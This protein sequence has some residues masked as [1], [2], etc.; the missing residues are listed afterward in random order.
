[1]TKPLESRVALLAVSKLVSLGF[2]V[3]PLRSPAQVVRH[4]PHKGPQDIP[5]EK[6]GKAPV[7]EGWA[8]QDALGIEDLVRLWGDG[9]P[10][11]NI[12]IRTGTVPGAGISVIVVDLDSVE[13]LMW[14][15]ENLPETQIAVHTARGQHW[16]YRAPPGRIGN[17][18]SVKIDGRPEPLQIDVRGDG[19]QAVAPSSVH[20]TGHRY[21][22]VLPWTPERV[23]SM[24]T[25]DP[26][27]FGR[28]SEWEGG[29]D[30]V[31][32]DGGERRPPVYVDHAFKRKRALAYL[33]HAPGTI[34]GQGTASNECLYYARALVFGLCLPP[35]EAARIMH[36]HDWN[37]RCVNSSGEPYPWTLEEL[38]H[39]CQDAYRLHFN[40]DFGYLLLEQKKN[41]EKQATEQDKDAALSRGARDMEAFAAS[42][43]QE[44][45]EA[46]W[47]DFAVDEQDV[48]DP[49]KRGWPLTDTGN[50]E[51]LVARFGEAVRY[52]E[53]REVWSA[54]D[55]SS[56]RW[57]V[58]AVALRR[59]SKVVARKIAEEI[60]AAEERL[61]STVSAAMDAAGSSVEDNDEAQEKIKAAEDAVESL[62]TWQK[63]SESAS[64]RVAMIEMAQ[65]EHTIAVGSDC[66]DRYPLLLNVKNGTL[67]LSQGDPRLLP[68]DRDYYLTKACLVAWDPAAE[69][70]TWRKCL[71]DW[72]GGDQD[73]ID[74]LQRAAGYAA[75]GSVEEEALFLF[76]G[77]GQNGKSTFLNALHSV[78]GPYATTA[79]AG[80]LMETR[81]D[82]ATPS[83][84]AGLAALVGVRLVVASESDES[85]RMSE[86]QVKAITCRDRIS[87]KR[88]YEAPF[89][90]APSHHVFLTTNSKPAISGTDDGIWRRL[91]PLEWRHRVAPSDRDNKLAEKLLAERSGI[92]RWIVEGAAAWQRRRLD[93]PSSVTS[94][95]QRYRSEQDTVG[96]FL[97]DMTEFTSPQTR[98]PKAQIRSVYEMWCEERGYMAFGAK[99]FSEQLLRTG[100]VSD[101]V[102]DWGGLAF[103]K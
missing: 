64:K 27:W 63:A 61:A 13:A 51:R 67:D 94:A 78:L 4:H 88:M 86:A 7:A 40:K 70:P 15:R 47:W 77:V 56:G 20:G 42:V 84:Q 39:K 14:A 1:M 21:S 93:P 62:R 10:G 52:V 75:T 17:K 54:W 46:Y 3:I 60:P 37:T 69:A 65:S 68:H 44:E 2:S 33:E 58:R 36:D 103:R 31:V 32:A 12:G 9:E 85:A 30:P 89:E 73:T 59:C 49:G 100:R 76:Y 92:L 38:G 11:Y 57:V 8:S 95:L 25:F 45:A 101:E 102:K 74:Y 48:P 98:S 19:G 26:A 81:I 16:Y 91:Q 29:E 90:F 23:W 41:N 97:H 79:P 28:T 96:M 53:D 6:R 99:K 71:H 22:G 66:F 50:A 55:S 35:E 87:A 80:L 83:Q 34:S 72:T 24:P 5:V 43:R 82:K 18:V